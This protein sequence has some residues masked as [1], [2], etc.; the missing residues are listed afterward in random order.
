MIPTASGEVC[1]K[2]KVSGVAMYK[3]SNTSLKAAKSSVYFVHVVKVLDC[4][5]RAKGR[6]FF[7]YKKFH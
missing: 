6:E 2:T 5:G 1:V 7:V 3:P 4:L